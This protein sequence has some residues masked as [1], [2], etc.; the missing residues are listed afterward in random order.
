M[1][2]PQAR[3]I[4]PALPARKTQKKI[5]RVP[6]RP[7]QAKWVPEAQM[8]DYLMEEHPELCN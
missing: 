2:K 5:V 4:A 3:K 1:R 7:V 8:P 6:R